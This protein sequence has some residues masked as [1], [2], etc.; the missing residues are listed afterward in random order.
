MPMIHDEQNDRRTDEND[1]GHDVRMRMMAIMVIMMMLM[2]MMMMMM[3][4]TAATKTRYRDLPASPR[5]TA[6]MQS[7]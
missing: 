4:A 7:P 3:M 5:T 2:M 1:F 6:M